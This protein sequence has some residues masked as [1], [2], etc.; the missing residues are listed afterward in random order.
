MEA[1]Y[2]SALARVCCSYIV[3]LSLVKISTY[4][5]DSSLLVCSNG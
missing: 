5:W 4:C 1:R 2:S 3:V